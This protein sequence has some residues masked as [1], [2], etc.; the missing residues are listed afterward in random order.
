MGF[1]DPTEGKDLCTDYQ[2]QINSNHV[3]LT[4]PAVPSFEV[5][6]DQP[7]KVPPAKGGIVVCIRTLI[8]SNGQRPI[9]AK[10]SADALAARYREVLYLYAASSPARS[11]YHFLKNS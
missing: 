11:A 4:H 10:N 1:D 7:L 5:M 8:A 3:I 6:V 2:S 9:S